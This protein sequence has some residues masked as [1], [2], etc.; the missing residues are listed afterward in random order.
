MIF[1]GTECMTTEY[2]DHYEA[3]CIG[4]EKDVPMNVKVPAQSP[5]MPEQAV[6]PLSEQTLA[7]LPEQAAAPVPALAAS[8]VSMRMAV[9]VIEKTP[10]HVPSSLNAATNNAVKTDAAR[11][12]LA[13]RP[14]YRVPRT[15]MKAKKLVR[16]KTIQE[17]L[18][19]L[20]E[21]E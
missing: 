17:E 5:V 19:N 3:V 2:P 6:A 12:H 4:D 10:S 18:R 20:P 21:S 1:A 7:P 14:P 13:Y 16:M 15:E 8:P 11:E 9:P